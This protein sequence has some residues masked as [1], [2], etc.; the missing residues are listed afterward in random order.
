MPTV[1]ACAWS[2]D[3]SA[4]AGVLETMRLDD[5]LVWAA[6]AFGWWLVLI[7]L[8]RLLR[9]PEPVAWA[10]VLSW[11]V[12]RLGMWAAPLIAHWLSVMV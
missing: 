10:A 5:V 6:A 7:V 1:A 12:A 4:L 11:P 8:L 3:V 9:M 2:P